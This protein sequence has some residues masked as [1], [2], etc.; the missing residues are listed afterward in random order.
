MYWTDI[1]ETRMDAG[2][3]WLPQLTFDFIGNNYSLFKCPFDFQLDSVAFSVGSPLSQD[4][5]V[6]YPDEWALDPSFDTMW[7]RLHITLRFDFTDGGGSLQFDS[8][9]DPVTVLTYTTG[10]EWVTLVSDHPVAG[11]P[12]LPTGETTETITTANMAG[13]VR[14]N[15]GERGP[16]CWVGFVDQATHDASRAQP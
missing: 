1:D 5:T 8:D 11:E 10:V 16:D 2:R 14:R 12:S 13:T 7:L 4:I 15:I 3:L 9:V 6:M